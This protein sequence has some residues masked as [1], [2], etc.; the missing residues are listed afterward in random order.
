MGFWEAIKGERVKLKGPRLDTCEVCNG[1]GSGGGANSICPDCNG[2]GNVTQMAGAMRFSLTCPRCDGTGKLRNVCTN[3]YGDG[4]VMRTE[5]V[6]VR[7]PAGARTGSR[8]RVGGKGNSGTVGAP[9]GDLYITIR[10]D[11]HPIFSRDGDDILIQVPISVSEAYLGAKIEVPTIDGR[12]LLKIPPGTHTG[13]K[14]R[15]RE[16]GVFN[17]RTNS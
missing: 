1:T 3:C 8:L 12:A 14:F 6:E 16:K 17:S 5:R 15:L 7:I 11:A 9:D 13:Q 4:R 10:V 2:S